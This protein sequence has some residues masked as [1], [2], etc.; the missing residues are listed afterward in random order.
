MT[1]RGTVERDYPLGLCFDGPLSLRLMGASAL[2]RAWRGASLGRGDGERLAISPSP[3]P[4]AVRI[5]VPTSP[6]FASIGVPALVGCAEDLSGLL[7]WYC[8][9]ADFLA[10]GG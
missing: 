3:R 6:W 4:A 2:G 9:L 5:F 1:G 7:P 8:G 10:A